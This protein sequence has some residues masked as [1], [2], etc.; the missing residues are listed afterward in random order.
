MPETMIFI[1]FL[2][3][4]K[5]IKTKYMDLFTF[6]ANKP[7]NYRAKNRKKNLVC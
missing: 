2:K 6:T 3:N 4:N 7:N 1:I 5:K